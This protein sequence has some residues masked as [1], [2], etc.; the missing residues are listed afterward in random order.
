MHR[1]AACKTCSTWEPFPEDVDSG[2]PSDFRIVERHRS[3]RSFVTFRSTKLVISS[4]SNDGKFL[5]YLPL[6]PPKIGYEV[7]FIRSCHTPCLRNGIDVTR[8]S[9]QHSTAV[10]STRQMIN[11][12]FPQDRLMCLALV[13]SL[14]LAVVAQEKKD[15]EYPTLWN[16]S[17]IATS[18]V[19]YADGPAK[20][21]V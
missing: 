12:A 4:D 19:D 1:Y 3:P 15:F 7:A 2:P 13:L 17:T 14:C 10:H 11:A 9:P 20:L 8:S 5:C 18:S 6:P 21:K 16:P